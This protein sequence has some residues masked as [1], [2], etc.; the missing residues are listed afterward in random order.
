VLQVDWIVGQLL[1]FLEREGL[2]DDTLV[3]LM[4]DN[5]GTD[6]TDAY[7]ANMR[8]HKTTAWRGGTRA[9]VFWRLPGVLEPGEVTE[10]CAHIDVLPTLAEVAG[11][12]LDDRARSQVEGRSA[13]GL[14]TGKSD[15]WPERTLF[16]HV[17][18]WPP[19]ERAKHRY[20]GATV[21]RGKFDLVRIESASR[22]RAYTDRPGFH[23]A[24][25][26]DGDWALYQRFADPLQTRNVAAEHPELVERLR[27]EYARWWEASR[28]FLIHEAE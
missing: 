6:G 25:T 15:R 10:S 28:E 26:P 22:G 19:G 1:D 3:L 24:A 27:G 17:A 8:G 2:A 21:R 11:A 13:W 14:L 4:G 7:N 5:G 20:E 12:S 18:R 23:R 16:A 9:K